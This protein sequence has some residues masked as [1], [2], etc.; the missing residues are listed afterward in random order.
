M[1]FWRLVFS[2]KS[3]PSRVVTAKVS[4]ARTASEAAAALCSRQ[5][6]GIVTDWRRPQIKVPANQVGARAKL[7]SSGTFGVPM[8]QID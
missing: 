6:Q 7:K 3:D 8:D 1:K 2:G 4:S 5:K